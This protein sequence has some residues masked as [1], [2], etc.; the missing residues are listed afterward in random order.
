MRIAVIAITRNGARLGA[1]LRDGLGSTDLHVLSKYK[2][3]AGKEAKPF[4]GELGELLSRLWPE[5]GGFVCIMATGIVVRLVAS[6]LQ[7]KET[8]PA[9]VVVDDAGRFAISLLS[10]HLGG[11]NL[12][13]ER[14]ATVI[15][16]R[17]VITT[18]TDSNELPSFDMIARAEGWEIDDISR[19]KNLNACLLDGEEIAIVD[20]TDLIQFHLQGKARFSV[21]ESLVNALRSSAKG[22]VLVSSRLV[23]PQFLNDRMLVLRPKSLYLGIGCNSGTTADEIAGTVATLLKRQ[24]LSMQSVAAIGTA[25]AKRDESGLL[26]FADRYSIPVR[27]YTSEEL[28]GVAVPSPASPHA[29]K[30]IGARGVAE[31]AALLASGNGEL[32]QSKYKSGNV[33]VA[34]A[35]RT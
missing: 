24:F 26:E 35:E 1:R 4:A 32:I 28:N 6:L 30:A 5:Y 33:T 27:F 14:T 12:L 25:E 23:P 19:V 13:A 16:A 31:P 29:L 17:A 8:D 10:G 9:V 3:Q 15:G 22:V 2:G 18:A 20:P 7:S 11:G 34:I 21:H